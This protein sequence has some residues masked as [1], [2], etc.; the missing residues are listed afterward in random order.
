MR[1]IARN[2]G[3]CRKCDTTIESTSRHEMVWCRCGAVAVDGGLEYLRRSATNFNDFE[4]L[5]EYT[6]EGSP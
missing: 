6:D 4:E 5:S 1:R 3:R 2:R